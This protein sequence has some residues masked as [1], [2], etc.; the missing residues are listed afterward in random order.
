MRFGHCHGSFRTVFVFGDVVV[1]VP[2]VRHWGAFIG[3]LAMNIQESLRYRYAEP[4]EPLCPVIW[5]VPGGWLLVMRYCEPVTL[6][7]LCDDERRT[8]AELG[9][10]LRPSNLGRLSDGRVVAIDYPRQADIIYNVDGERETRS[11][12]V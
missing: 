7:E 1:K 9:I 3:G 8:F 4:G 2:R 5:S 6:E 10:E 12:S 11:G